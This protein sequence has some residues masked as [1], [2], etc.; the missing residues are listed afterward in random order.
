MSH[1]GKKDDTF[2]LSL[3]NFQIS[4]FSLEVRRNVRDSSTNAEMIGV[5]MVEYIGIDKR[6]KRV[7][8]VGQEKVKD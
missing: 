5:E 3:W 6:L 1:F 7:H 8:I 4:S 2:V